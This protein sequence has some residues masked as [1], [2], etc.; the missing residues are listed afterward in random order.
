MPSGLFYSVPRI[1]DVLYQEN[2]VLLPA[3]VEY[4]ISLPSSKINAEKGRDF[5]MIVSLAPT[6]I[7]VR[8]IES[9][10]SVLENLE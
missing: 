1:R 2:S 6:L 5:G 9:L 8:A 4:L 10:I 7:L 3:I